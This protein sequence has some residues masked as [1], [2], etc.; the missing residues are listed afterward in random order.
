MKQALIIH[1]P[2]LISFDHNHE[3]FMRYSSGIYSEPKCSNLKT[4]SAL[5]VGYTEDFWIVKN[6]FGKQ[7]GENGFFR[8]TR[9]K[10]NHCG[11][12]DEAFILE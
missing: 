1:G 12:T 7:W 9:H 4:H 5:L 3:S 2:I 10:R 11:I 6:S 8:I